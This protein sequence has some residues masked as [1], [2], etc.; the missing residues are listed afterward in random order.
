MSGSPKASIFALIDRVLPYLAFRLVA[1]MSSS[2]PSILAE[3]DVCFFNFS[4]SGTKCFKSDRL[5]FASE[6][7]NLNSV[8]PQLT[9]LSLSRVN[10]ITVESVAN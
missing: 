3:I 9:L 2:V 10:K 7:L 1:L 8:L 6:M 5:M 4:N